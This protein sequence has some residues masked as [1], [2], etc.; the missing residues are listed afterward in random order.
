VTLNRASGRPAREVWRAPIPPAWSPDLAA[1]GPTET[2]WKGLGEGVEVGGGNVERG[3]DGGDGAVD[4][5]GGE[6]RG[7]AG[8]GDSGCGSFR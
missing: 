5:N 8:R 3:G 6:E 1:I 7:E 4:L 2:L